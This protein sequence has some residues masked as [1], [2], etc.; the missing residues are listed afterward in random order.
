MKLEI[1]PITKY[2]FDMFNFLI[3]EHYGNAIA[4]HPATFKVDNIDKE[5]PKCFN[6]GKLIKNK[7]HKYCGYCGAGID[8][9]NYVR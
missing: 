2:N 9:S 8:W 1:V 5:N 4:I 3:K 6:C 7:D